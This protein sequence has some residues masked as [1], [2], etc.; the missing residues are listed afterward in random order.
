MFN[1]KKILCGLFIA[2]LAM[3][4]AGC[5]V[6]RNDTQSDSDANENTILA[7]YPATPDADYPPP[8]EQL[9]AAEMFG[10]D[11]LENE[12]FIAIA[13]FHIGFTYVERMPLPKEWDVQSIVSAEVVFVGDYDQMRQWHLESEGDLNSTIPLYHH[14]PLQGTLSAQM[15]IEFRDF[16]HNI[17]GR[18]FR[19]AFAGN[20]ADDFHVIFFSTDYEEYVRWEAARS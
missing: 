5:A 19:P 9:S 2:F 1:F 4:L 12:V 20:T 15:V 8:T 13:V 11:V 7:E 14:S 17:I 3:I 18:M 16:Y 6:M 10:T